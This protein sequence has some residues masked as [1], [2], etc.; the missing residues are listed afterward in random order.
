MGAFAC[1]SPAE[2]VVVVDSDLTVPTELALVRA[3]VSDEE[4]QARSLN[5]FVLEGAGAPEV[6]FSFGVVPIDGDADRTVQIEL[7]AFDDDRI[8]LFSSRART[9]FASGR[10]LRLPM[11]LAGSCRTTSCSAQETCG[12]DGCVS[13]E[14]S[15]ES[16]VEV[17][18]GAEL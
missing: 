8:L 14:R 2:L 12:E 1:G 7:S 6:P 17:E 10:L 16:L 13:P 5:D 11:F 15:V 3:V 4:G 18:P 9:R